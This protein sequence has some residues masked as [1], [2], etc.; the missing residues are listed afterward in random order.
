MRLS[1]S[2]ILPALLLLA[3]LSASAWAWM[4]THPYR[5]IASTVE[6]LEAPATIIEAAPAE[7]PAPPAPVTAPETALVVEPPAP[8]PVAAPAVE[9]PAPVETP[10]VEPVAPVAPAETPVETPA[11]ETP[12]PAPTEQ[13]A[14]EA[15]ATAP[16]QEPTVAPATETQQ[17]EGTTAKD[18]PHDKITKMLGG[19]PDTVTLTPE[20][21][22][23][24][25][26]VNQER[27]KSGVPELIVAPLL[28]ATAREKSKEMHDLNYWG[29]ESPVKG[30]RTALYRVMGALPEAPL[31]MTVGENLYFCRAVLVDS[32]HQALMNSPTHK[33][34]ILH[35]DYRYIGVGGYIAEDKRFWITEHFLTIEY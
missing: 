25:D 21:Q 6:A 8:A 31:S 11:A 18:E 32:G 27:K 26:L 16:A 2:R 35:P 30:K 3:F 1:P 9:A 13:P 10:V 33:K 24:V 14:A 5:L 34:N 4:H 28:V 15:P 23:F 22:R 19:A 12:T 7:E 17:G 20:E 29:H